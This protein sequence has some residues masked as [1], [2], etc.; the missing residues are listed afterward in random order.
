[1]LGFM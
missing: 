1:M